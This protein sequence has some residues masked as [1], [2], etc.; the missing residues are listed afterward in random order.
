MPPLVRN[1][2]RIQRLF[3]IRPTGFQGAVQSCFFPKE[4]ASSVR[5]RELL[6]FDP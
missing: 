6:S 4:L 3:D 5:P 1:V 2:A